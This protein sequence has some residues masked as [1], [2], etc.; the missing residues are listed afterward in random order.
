[1]KVLV[2][3]ATPT[4]YSDT[5][6]PP[7]TS[8][9]YF[10]RATDGRQSWPHIERRESDDAGD[11]TRARGSVLLRRRSRVGVADASGQGNTGTIQNATWTT[12]GKY[13]KAL[14][15]NGTNALITIPDAASLRLTTGMTLEAWV[16]PTTVSTGWRDVIYK[17]ND[18][19]FL[20]VTSS[21]NGMPAAGGTF[22][23]VYGTGTLAV[24][25]WSHLAATYDGTTLRLYVNG[26]QVSSVALTGN[27]A[28]SSNPLQIGGDSIYGQYFQG[29]IDE[30][31]VY[32]VA[33]TPT[34]IQADANTPIGSVGLPVASFTPSSI[35]F[36][37]QQ[38]NTTSDP[39]IVTLT[40]AGAATLTI[41]SIAITGPHSVDFNQ[42]NSCG[43]TLAPAAPAS[44]ASPSRRQRPAAEPR[45]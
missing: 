20:E 13:G 38:T 31:R 29:T 41:S 11:S 3:P 21:R 8:Y 44:S 43:T 10:V 15:F 28:T 5:G 33:R 22:G 14:V 4:T 26:V 2:T 36:G 17:G 40:N 27:I 35:S 42:G 12:S 18:N 45:R 19:Y 39:Q 7:N 9:S 34:Q 32:N 1:M 23:E 30:V 24:N 16:M 6:L 25:T 37:S